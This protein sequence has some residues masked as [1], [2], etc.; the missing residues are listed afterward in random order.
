MGNEQRQARGSWLCLGLGCGAV[1]LLGLWHL[2]DVMDGI[3]ETGDTWLLGWYLCLLAGAE[4]ALLLLGGFLWRRRRGRPE[5]FFFGAVLLLGL[6]YLVVLAP[7]SAPDEISHY[8]SAYQLSNRLLSWEPADGQGNVWIRAE[9]AF[10]E[11]VEGVRRDDGQEKKTILGQELTEGTYRLLHQGETGER[12]EGRTVSCQYPVR[13]TPLVYVPQALGMTLGRLLRVNGFGLLYLG[14]L[15]NLICFAAV[16][17]MAVKRLPFGKGAVTAAALLPMSLHLAASFSY[18]AMLIALGTYITAV[19]ADLAWRA[20]R[21]RARDA[22]ALAAAAAIMGPC[23]M[24]YGVMLGL[25]LLIPVRRFGGWKAWIL[26]AAAV[27][28]AYGIAMAVVNLGT[29]A[30]YTGSGSSYVA[31]AGEE[32]YTFQELLHR[33]LHVLQ[34]CYNTLAWEGETLFSGMLGE[35]LGNMDPVLNTPYAV[36][37]AMTAV[38]VVLALKKPG[39]EIWVT[40]GQRL[41]IWLLGLACLGALMF[42]MLLA[43]TPASATK[44]KGVQGRYLLPIL[45]SLLLTIRNS[46]VVRTGVEDAGLLFAMAAMNAYVVIR[47]FSVVCIRIP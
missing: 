16:G 23:K 3:R 22:A 47:L 37:L 46:R 21:V 6:L 42:S 32:G 33:P 11:D 34:M 4:A 30:Y 25:C 41:W 44:I 9:D 40:M 29:V 36:L 26:S 31:W 14:R 19:C 38:I 5:H 12:P 27:L 1:L 7:L 35:A 2:Q 20:P 17:S 45:P 18:D 15:F 28:G 43:W 10:I 8:I 39:E 13:T 24:V